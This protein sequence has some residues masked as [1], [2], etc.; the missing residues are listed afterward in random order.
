MEEPDSLEDNKTGGKKLILLLILKM[1]LF[2]C[3]RDDHSEAKLSFN[4]LKLITWIVRSV[5]VSVSILYSNFGVIIFRR[6]VLAGLV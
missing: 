1:M 4:K 6:S 5:E 2:F 3:Q